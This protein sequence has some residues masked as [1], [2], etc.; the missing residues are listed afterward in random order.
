M[1][2]A[3]RSA[4][5]GKFDMIERAG[6]WCVMPLSFPCVQDPHESISGD[7]TVG[8]EHGRQRREGRRPAPG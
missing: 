4:K 3:N 1:V 5:F 2:M 7:I 6:G 8:S